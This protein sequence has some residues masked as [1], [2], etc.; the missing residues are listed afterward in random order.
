MGA[1]ETM[2]ML[3]ETAPNRNHTTPR[4]MQEPPR[5]SLPPDETASLDVEAHLDG[6]EQHLSD[7]QKQV[8]KLQ[9]LA[10]LGTVATIL[11]HEFNNLLTPIL[12][13]SQYA[14][15]S[16]DPEFLR[17]AVEKTHKNAQRLSSL[18][19]KILGIATD[20]RMGPIAAEIKPL[21]NSA[22]ECMG[23]D[24]GKDGIQVI[25]NVDEGLKARA[26]VGSLQQVLFNL[27]L[28][29]RQAMLDKDGCLTLS[30]RKTEE[31]HVEITLADTGHGIPPE[32]MDKIFEPFFSTRE[33][34]T[35]Q[36]RQGIGLGLHICRQLM[37]EQG[38]EI[39]VERTSSK[40]TTFK[41]ILP[42]AD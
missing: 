4:S 5:S 40:G 33:H 24:P 1:L 11:A 38:G 7:L 27:V 39:S 25:I 19:T 30:A 17:S 35:Q 34:E 31:G 2:N 23:R 15:N 12:S 16:D 36:D 22:V 8:Q 41:L 6:L 29:A 21:L 20:D 42:A 32:L 14:L 37:E 9:R 10:S 18:C 28:N 13:Y 3:D 26:H